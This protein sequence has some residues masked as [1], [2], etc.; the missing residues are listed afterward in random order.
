LRQSA[1]DLAK[2]NV[3]RV[4]ASAPFSISTALVTVIAGGIAAILSFGREPIEVAVIAVVV[5]AVAILL[6]LLSVFIF[7]V[8]VAALRQR[9]E[10]RACLETVERLDPAQISARLSDFA[11][12]ADDLL[13]DC[14]ANGGY[15]REHQA[16]G[17]AWTREVVEFLSAHCA[18]ERALA[19]AAASRDAGPF[20]PRLRKRIA[21]LDTIIGS[22]S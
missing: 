16:Q 3:G 14:K 1:W 11:R 22:V 12:R 13:A 18:T 6:C 10:L 9:N 8:S 15:T 20:I 21:V 2:A 19:F 7:Q 5:G 4:Y 17:E